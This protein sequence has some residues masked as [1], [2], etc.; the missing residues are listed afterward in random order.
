[1]DEGT[2]G[3]TRIRRSRVWT[4]DLGI[5]VRFLSFFGRRHYILYIYIIIFIY[6]WEYFI[7]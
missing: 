1:M 2:R 7:I 5:I 3:G 6:F 4:E